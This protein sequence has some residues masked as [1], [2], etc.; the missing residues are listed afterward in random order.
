MLATVILALPSCLLA[1]TIGSPPHR[2]DVARYE[3]SVGQEFAN[4]VAVSLSKLQPLVPP[5]Y[6]IL[7]ASVLGF[8]GPDQGIVAITNYRG[9]KPKI[10]G[11]SI[12]PSAA[13]ISVSIVVAEPPDAAGAGLSA[14]G[15]Y[16]LYTIAVYTSNPLFAA[17][18]RMTSMPVEFVPTIRVERNMD[19]AT[20][21][22]EMFVDVPSNESPF[23]AFNTGNGYATGPG[24]LN[25]VF[26]YNRRK[27]K[28][29]LHYHNT[30]YRIGNAVGQVYTKPDTWLGE[31][32][33]GGG[34]GVCPPDPTTGYACVVTS[35][36]N[37]YYD[38]GS[39]GDLM[40]IQ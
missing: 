38:D 34:I 26:W 28:T 1:Q 18:L 39:R 10:S 8:G 20:G 31:L 37:L 30:P 9:I 5:G 2:V 35:S 19:D 27:G 16:H 25:A 40:L 33:K 12:M 29:A 21:V 11:I 13:E 7:P 32:V 3:S 36:L 23:K 24:M 14:H 15:A 17:A 6:V 4:T 22:G